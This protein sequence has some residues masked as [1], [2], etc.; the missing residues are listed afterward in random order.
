MTPRQKRLEKRRKIRKAAKKEW[1]D[2]MRGLYPNFK[3]KQ[4]GRNSYRI[5]HPHPEMI[6]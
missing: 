5:K 1:A 4:W 2:Q 6:F 3:V